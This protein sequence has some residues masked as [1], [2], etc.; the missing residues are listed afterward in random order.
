MSYPINFL[1]VKSSVDCTQN[2]QISF[3]KTMPFV[4]NPVTAVG[5]VVSF[6][7]FGSVVMVTGSLNGEKLIPLSRAWTVKVY[8]VFGRRVLI[9]IEVIVP[10]QV[11]GT[12]SWKTWKKIT[13]PSSV[14]DHESDTWV[15]PTS[16][17]ETT[18]AVGGTVSRGSVTVT[19]S[20]R[21]ELSPTTSTAYT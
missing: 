17:T 18:G 11:T 12:P 8:V 7:F 14:D 1:A 5:G 9:V 3:S 2:S 15:G 13:G 6:G 16:V 4:V 10:A 19:V 20:L 21:L